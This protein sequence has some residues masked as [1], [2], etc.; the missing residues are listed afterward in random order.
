MIVEAG[1]VNRRDLKTDD[2]CEVMNGPRQNDRCTVPS[3]GTSRLYAAQLTGIMALSNSLL[4]ALAKLQTS[5][6]FWGS[7]FFK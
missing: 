6:N 7:V 1:A 4:A 2:T 3:P 5:D